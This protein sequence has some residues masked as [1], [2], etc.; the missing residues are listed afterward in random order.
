MAGP[1]DLPCDAEHRYRGR[2]CRSYD[3][4]SKGGLPSE[5]GMTSLSRSHMRLLDSTQNLSSYHQGI[6]EHGP[7]AN[8]EPVPVERVS[9]SFC[10]C[11]GLAEHEV[12]TPGCYCPK[13]PVN[14]K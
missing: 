9:N 11:A 12:Q 2:T 3:S 10:E 5:N 7:R 6:S 14:S 1:R 13:W 4:G 8:V